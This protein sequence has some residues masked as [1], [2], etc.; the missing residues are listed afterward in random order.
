MSSHIAHTGIIVGVDGSPSS[1]VAVR[2][3]VGEA[4]MHNIA[5]VNSAR[6]P[7]IVAGQC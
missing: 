2:W 4:T 6:T 1:A 5:V 7:V 3:A